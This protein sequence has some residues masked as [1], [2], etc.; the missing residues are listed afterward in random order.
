MGVFPGLSFDRRLDPDGAVLRDGRAFQM[1]VD[2]LGN[3]REPERLDDK[4]AH[5]SFV[6]NKVFNSVLLQHILVHRRQY[7]IL[8][9]LA[10]LRKTDQ[11][12]PVAA[13]QTDHVL[14]GQ[15]A[16]VVFLL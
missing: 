5:F 9:A 12:F 7:E 1:E 13:E 16:V 2:H 4:F 6:D 3:R 14:P 15:Q 10:S 8:L 11:E